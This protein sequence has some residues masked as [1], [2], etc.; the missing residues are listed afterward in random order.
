M[1]TERLVETTSRFLRERNLSG[2]AALLAPLHPGDLADL[3]RRLSERDRTTV[4]L[5]LPDEQAA[6]VLE[7]LD[8]DERVALSQ[9]LADEQLVPLL[10]EMATDEVTDL[11]G[12]L[13]RDRAQRLLRQMRRDDA[14]EVAGL[15]AFPERSAGGL[16]TTDIVAISPDLTVGR[17]IQ[18]VRDQGREVELLY[19]VYVTEAARLVGVVTL[20]ELIAAPTDRTIR[21]MM[22]TR[23]VTVAPLD[24]QEAVAAVA[25]KYSLLAVPVVDDS[26]RLL[27]VVTSD[28]LLGVVET[29]G[30]EDV[31]GLTGAVGGAQMQARIFPWDVLGKR[32]GFLVLNL[33]LDI[34]AVIV[35]SRFTG[36]LEATL[37]L[38]FFIPA[39]MASA[40]N[41][42]AQ[43]LALAV[44]GLATGRFGRDAW[45]QV[46]REGT[47]GAVV[48]AVCGLAVGAY[49]ALWQQDLKLGLVVGGSMWL[50][51]LIAAPLGMVIPLTMD[52]LGVDPAITSGPLIT[53]I[54]D[55]LALIMYFVLAIQLLR[56]VG[57]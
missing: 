15:M 30:T 38:A 50:G 54:A 29:E 20:R 6:L 40:G 41:V 12:E 33:F 1:L 22:H 57:G 11:L 47:T 34:L 10:S 37:A 52:R 44:R 43:S 42:G 32:S 18:D 5:L 26:G 14:T 9:T 55:I 39:L 51:L 36:T 56:A 2:L 31:L 24:D 53:T 21:A 28:D 45:R 7:S 27:G 35:I 23:L 49:A 46:G 19:Y 16:M 17:A 48:G 4:L 13:P 25:R 3:L 8:P